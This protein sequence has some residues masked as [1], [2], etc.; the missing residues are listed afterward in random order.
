MI[1]TGGG[2]AGVGLAA[3]IFFA[4]TAFLGAV[5]FL[6][7]ATG[8][9]R[10]GLL[11]VAFFTPPP[12]LFAEGESFEERGPFGPQVGGGVAA[13]LAVFEAALRLTTWGSL[14]LLGFGLL[15]L[16]LRGKLRLRLL[17]KLLGAG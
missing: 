4:T 7:A 14:L 8:F 5:T 12:T 17:Q 6:T 9:L 16:G 15:G 2:G 11:A 1:F 3:T 13:G 10:T